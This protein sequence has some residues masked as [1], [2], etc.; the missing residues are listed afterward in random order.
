MTEAMYAVHWKSKGEFGGSFKTGP[1]TREQ[2]E[3]VRASLL[4]DSSAYD[5]EI[6]PA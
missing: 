4:D 6:R 2:A 5:I 3:K 1:V